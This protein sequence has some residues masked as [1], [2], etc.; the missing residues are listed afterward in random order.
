MKDILFQLMQ[1]V[2]NNI[3]NIQVDFLFFLFYIKLLFALMIFSKPNCQG[4]AIRVSWVEKNQ[5]INQRG[6]G[7]GGGIY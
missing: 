5:K 1:Q 2:N 7:E 3:R 4:V 6:E